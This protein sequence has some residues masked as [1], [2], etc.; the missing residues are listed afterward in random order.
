MDW[1]ALVYPDFDGKLIGWG[2]C[3]DYALVLCPINNLQ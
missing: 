1:E 3:A 2:G